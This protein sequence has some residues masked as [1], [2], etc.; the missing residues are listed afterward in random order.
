MSRRLTAG[1]FLIVLSLLVVRNQPGLGQQTPGNVAQGVIPTAIDRGV[2]PSESRAFDSPEMRRRR[3]LSV[4]TRARERTG[5]ARARY[6][7]GRVMVK[8]RAGR[9][10]S[11]RSRLLAALAPAVAQG[12]QPY[13][14]YDAVRIGDDE[15]PELF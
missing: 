9:A 5:R 1:T 2:L 15:D 11:V 10:A 4:T 3:S 14:D 6:V 13:A 8:F 12:R 7:P